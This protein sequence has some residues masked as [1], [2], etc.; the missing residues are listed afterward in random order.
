VRGT[1]AGLQFPVLLSYFGVFQRGLGD[2]LLLRVELGGVL[3]VL[4]RELLLLLA[5]RDEEVLVVAEV[6]RLL[7]LAVLERYVDLLE[8]V[9][10][11]VDRSLKR[12]FIL[13][14]ELI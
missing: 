11:N 8:V 7:H 6:E 9:D 3:L 13:N 12:L 1:A 14:L 4:P 2:K 10:G 5:H